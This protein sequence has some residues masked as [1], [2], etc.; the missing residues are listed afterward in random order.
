MSYIDYLDAKAN[1]YLINNSSTQL[2]FIKAVLKHYYGE[3]VYYEMLEDLWHQNIT[4][5]EKG[6]AYLNL[7]DNLPVIKDINTII[8]HFSEVHTLTDVINMA[9][10]IEHHKINWTLGCSNFEKEVNTLTVILTEV[11]LKDKYYSIQHV[12][13]ELDKAVADKKMFTLKQVR[14]ELGF[15]RYETFQPWLKCYFGEKYLN[16]NR[17]NGYINLYEYQE[18]METFFL[19]FNE[20]EFD[21]ESNIEV[22]KERLGQLLVHSKDIKHIAGKPHNFTEDVQI[23]SDNNNLKTPKGARL[24]PYNRAS[25]IK[26]ELP[27]LYKNPD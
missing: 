16:S 20:T 7:F 13:D 12:D 14:E 1:S 9:Y 22:Y 18:I 24:F 27:K 4:N 6:R 11:L 8:N 25:L 21:L 19:S 5:A 3:E 15:K 23:V 2:N 10:D 17:N 26:A